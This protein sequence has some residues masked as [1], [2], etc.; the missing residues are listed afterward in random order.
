MNN[1]KETWDYWTVKAGF[2]GSLLG[3][4]VAS[5]VG[6]FPVVGIKRGWDDLLSQPFE[7][8][9][10]GIFYL[11]TMVTFAHLHVIWR[12]DRARFPKFKQASL[13]IPATT[14]GAIAFFFLYF[15]A[16]ALSQRLHF[17]LITGT[18]YE[19]E[20][21]RGVGLLICL[22]AGI[23]QTL[24][25]L[26]PELYSQSAR[27]LKHP[28]LFATLLFLTGV[29]EVFGTW[30]TLVG[31]PGIFVVMKWTAACL[32]TEPN[33]ELHPD[34]LSHWRLIPFIY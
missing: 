9:F 12:K 3:F 2:Q 20:A 10:F 6:V 23:L 16:N 1:K 29:P 31:I 17:C 32:E 33:T 7:L 30:F 18:N 5:F 13:N 24:A 34:I 4:V 28:C 19:V 21:V 11:T 14:C 8:V 22:T 26:K 25:L 27:R 15:S